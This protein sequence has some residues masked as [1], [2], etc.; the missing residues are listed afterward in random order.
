MHGGG[1]VWLTLFGELQG[2]P[3]EGEEHVQFG[4][5]NAPPEDIIKLVI[6]ELH[7]S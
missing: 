1:R 5:V 2:R 7:L 6:G 4:L 3:E